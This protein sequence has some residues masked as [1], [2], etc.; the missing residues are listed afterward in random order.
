MAYVNDS[1]ILPFNTGG[2]DGAVRAR[3]IVCLVLK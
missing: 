3:T 2:R 1:S